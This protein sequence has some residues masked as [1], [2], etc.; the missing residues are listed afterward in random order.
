MGRPVGEPTGKIETG[1][2]RVGQ[3]IEIG[4]GTGTEI[5]IEIEIGRMAP[6]GLVLVQARGASKVSSELP[7]PSLPFPSLPFPSLPFP[8]LPFPS[9]P[10]PSLPIST[11]YKN[12][13]TRQEQAWLMAE[14][15]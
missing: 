9:L 11:F 12:S 8:S 3:G 10:F 1:Q 15:F 7:F 2:T 5:E 14:L 13:V 6:E 4:T